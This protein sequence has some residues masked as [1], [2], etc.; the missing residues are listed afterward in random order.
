MQS[1]IDLYQCWVCD[2]VL[3]RMAYMVN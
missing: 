2:I 1:S 3:V